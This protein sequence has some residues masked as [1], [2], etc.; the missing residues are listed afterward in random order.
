MEQ[1]Y[2]AYKS[3]ACPGAIEISVTP[4]VLVYF[5]EKEKGTRKDVTDFVF[6]VARRLEGTAV[7]VNAVFRGD[8]RSQ[9]GDIWSET[10]D[11]ELWYWYSNQ[12][13][14]ESQSADIREVYY[15]KNKLLDNYRLDKVGINMEEICWP[16]DD[17]R[18]DFVKVLQEV[19]S[20]G[21]EGG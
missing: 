12:F 8:L 5:A 19:M 3:D 2:P 20:L 6:K 18:Q 16:S 11:D 10:V 1:V 9:G 13:L 17:I 21:P 7:L 14:R 15:E 4:V